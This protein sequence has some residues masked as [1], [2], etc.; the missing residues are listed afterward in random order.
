MKIF[1]TGGTGFLGRHLIE[2]LILD[3]HEVTV[4]TRSEKTANNVFKQ[5]SVKVIEG[6]P[7]KPGPW[8][9]AIDGSDA[10]INLCGEKILDK[11]WN[12]EVKQKLLHSRIPPTNHIVEAIAASKEKP[13]VLIS[14][15]A[16]GYYSDRG[17][18]IVT[19]QDMRGHD[20]PAQLCQAWED[21]ANKAATMTRVVFIRTGLVLAKKGGALEEMAQPFKFFAGGPIGSGTQYMSWIHIKDHI[22]IVKLCLTNDTI[23]GPINLTA[24]NPVTNS[25]FTNAL[26]KAMNRPS[27]LRVPP[28]MLKLMFGEGAA[29]LLEG[30]RVIPQ[31]ALNTGYSFK[32][33]ILENALDDLLKKN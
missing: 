13:T 25:E 20:F 11:K 6:D 9:Q 7:T 5:G 2:E 31:K 22:E 28:F 19:E 33:E 23:S 16:I 10:V 26:G 27:W 29:L 1:I 30:Q 15:S 24:P 21:A 14:G 17:S 8:Q 18:A 4:L 3:N 12:N 32:Y